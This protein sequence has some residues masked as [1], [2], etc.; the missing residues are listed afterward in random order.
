MPQHRADAVHGAPLPRAEPGR[1]PDLHRL[2]DQVVRHALRLG[3]ADP[4]VP[5]G[6]RLRAVAGRRVA[7]DEARDD[8]GGRGGQSHPDAAAHREADE[9]DL[10]DS[11]RFEECPEIRDHLLDRIGSGRHLGL[12]VAPNVVAQH[13]VPVGQRRGLGVPEPERRAERVRHDDDRSLRRALEKVVRLHRSSL[14]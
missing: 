12:P 6:L 11:E 7:E 5:A 9:V 13:A 14:T 8:V 10:E 3:D 2:L 4:L 1:E